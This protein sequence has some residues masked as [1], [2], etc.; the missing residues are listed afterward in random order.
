MHTR[1]QAVL[2]ECAASSTR[3]GQA[4]QHA[5]PV[6]DQ[7]RDLQKRQPV[8]VR[9]ALERRAAQHGSIFRH[10]L[11]PAGSNPASRAKSTAASV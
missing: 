7:I 6:I 2:H 9:E 4:G 11:A 3:A 5:E 1:Q 8:R 10:E